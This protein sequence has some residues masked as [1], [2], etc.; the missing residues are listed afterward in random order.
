MTDAQTQTKASLTQI[1]PNQTSYEEN[2]H[3]PKYT[4]P[5]PHSENTKSKK[6]KLPAK[7]I[8]KTQFR[9]KANEEKEVQNDR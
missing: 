1:S 9:K 6:P 8:W 5:N 2:N 4:K 7:A 3:K